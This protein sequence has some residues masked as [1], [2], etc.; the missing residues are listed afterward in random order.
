MASHRTDPEG[1][2]SLHDQHI[3]FSGY[4]VWAIYWQETHLGNTNNSVAKIAYFG[5]RT[6]NINK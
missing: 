3:I 4:K 1:F 2:K 5:K 6:F